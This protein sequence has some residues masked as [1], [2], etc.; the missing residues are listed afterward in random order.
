MGKDYY[1]V[2]EIDKR[3]TDDEI[4]KAYRTMAL[5][6]HP[7]KNPGNK[8]AEDKFKDVAEAYEVLSDPEK[9]DTYDRFGDI[10]PGMNSF[11]G[12][13][14]NDIF[15]TVFGSSNPFEQEFFSERGFPGMFPGQGTSFNFNMNPNGGFKK[16]G[17]NMNNMNNNTKKRDFSYL[18]MKEGT[19]IIHS[20]DVSLEDLYKGLTKQ[21]KI[22]R[23]VI[24]RSTGALKEEEQIIK[25]DIDPG[26]KNGMRI[27]FSKKANE[28]V[29]ELTGDFVVLIKE[30]EH[31]RFKR[32]NKNDL[33]VKESINLSDVKKGFT[34]DIKIID[35]TI[36]TIKVPSFNNTGYLHKIS[37]GGM[38][39]RVNGKQVG[40]GDLFISFDVDL[41]K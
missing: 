5:K 9:K 26:F 19:D 8:E 20:L 36:K 15:N 6:Y 40:Y 13:N 7:D 35:G 1:K 33:I 16:S 30:I 22:K 25:V 39:V 31:Q 29:D 23:S 28:K 14:A 17:I 32:I 11:S 2:L 4:K 21:L 27:K 34:K 41:T 10:K 12:V 38:P 37:D 3:A 24:D 18:D